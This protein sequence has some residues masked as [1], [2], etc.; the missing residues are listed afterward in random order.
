MKNFS[1]AFLLLGFS[2]ISYSCYLHF[3]IDSSQD[4]Y[5]SYLD[6][7]KLGIIEASGEDSFWTS[8]E[9]LTIAD[10]VSG[11]IGPTIL[12][13]DLLTLMVTTYV[14][15]CVLEKL[16]NPKVPTSCN[17]QYGFDEM[18]K[19]DAFATEKLRENVIVLYEQFFQKVKKIIGT[20]DP[21]KIKD[22]IEFIE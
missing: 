14:S 18:F 11:C 7:I 2:P 10:G 21:E 4:G 13:A 17:K 16:L 20:A 1:C 6:K 8:K 5:T 9:A 3:K 15:G 19:V 22:K 12:I